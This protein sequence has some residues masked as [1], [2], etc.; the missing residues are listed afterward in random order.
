LTGCFKGGDM[1]EVSVKEARE[2][3]SL[4]LDRT[5]KG[6]EILISRRGKKVARLV[7]VGV[8]EKRLP[9]LSAFRASIAVNGAS[10]SQ[11]VVDSR[12]MERY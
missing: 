11:T 2:R 8:S 9:D 7:P 1:E 10:L 12:D 3:I 4:L 5:Q 6:E